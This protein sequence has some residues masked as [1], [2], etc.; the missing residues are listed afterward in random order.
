MV[1]CIGVKQTEKKQLGLVNLQLVCACITKRR[2][3]D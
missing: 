1:I 3:L 2:T